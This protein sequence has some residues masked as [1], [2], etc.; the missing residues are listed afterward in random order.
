MR[1]SCRIE[2]GFFVCKII[3]VSA[4]LNLKL[5]IFATDVRTCLC[6]MRR[7]FPI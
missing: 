3:H 1:A 6:S 5:E 2:D 7:G 4:W